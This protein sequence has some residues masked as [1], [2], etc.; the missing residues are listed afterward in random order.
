MSVGALVC[1][2]R[3]A[4]HFLKKTAIFTQNITLARYPSPKITPFTSLAS[5]VYSK[6]LKIK[7]VSANGSSWLLVCPQ[8][9]K[10]SYRSRLSRPAASSSERIALGGSAGAMRIAIT[11]GARRRTEKHGKESCEQGQCPRHNPTAQ[12]QR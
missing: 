12:Q 6:H 9:S 11:N 4:P 5:S 7:M 10:E 1:E 3:D 8:R 2:H